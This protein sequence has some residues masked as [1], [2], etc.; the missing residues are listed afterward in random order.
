MSGSSIPAAIRYRAAHSL[1][2]PPL[3]TPFPRTPKGSRS[4][5]LPARPQ[6]E[7]GSSPP[8]VP[9][10]RRSW[11]TQD[12]R[13]VTSW[14]PNG[15]YL[16]FMVQNNATRQD[17]YYID[18]NGDKKLTPFI[19]SPANETDAVLSP[20]DKWLAYLSDES[21]RYE[22]Y[23]TAFPGTRRKM[24]GLQWWRRFRVVECG[25]QATLLHHRRQAHDGANSER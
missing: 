6:A 16:F 23:V 5:P 2:L 3:P 14:S 17:V 21:G 22:V 9:A 13:H 24:A 11:S 7:C 8:A 19:E 1:M 18:L 15:R 20:N 4:A 10:I 12:L 25:W